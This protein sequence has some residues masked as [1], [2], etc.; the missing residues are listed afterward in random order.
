MINN[1]QSVTRSTK[2]PLLLF[3]VCIITELTVTEWQTILFVFLFVCK[4]NIIF[5]KQ[6]LLVRS[7]GPRSCHNY[8]LPFVLKRYTFPYS[9]FVLIRSVSHHKIHLTN[10]LALISN[11]LLT[12]YVQ[13]TYIDLVFRVLFYIVLYFDL[14]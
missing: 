11:S 4:F 5:L 13:L 6:Y 10:P 3:T 12:T 1:S 8:G 9:Q 2:S 14:S 7:A